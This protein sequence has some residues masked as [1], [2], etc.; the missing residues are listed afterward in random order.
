MPQH[1]QYTNSPVQNFNDLD[2]LLSDLQKFGLIHDELRQPIDIMM[3]NLNTD[4]TLK[5]LRYIN[6]LTIN[7]HN[8]DGE[9]NEEYDEEGFDDNFVPQASELFNY[10]EPNQ[11]EQFIQDF[12]NVIAFCIYENGYGLADDVETIDNLIKMRNLDEYR[13]QVKVTV[14]PDTQIKYQAIA[15]TVWF[16]RN[17]NPSRV[18]IYEVSSNDYT[19]PLFVGYAKW[20]GNGWCCYEPLLKLAIE[21]STHLHKREYTY[22]YCWRGFLEELVD[23]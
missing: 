17:Q 9:E 13:M 8:E 12:R 21:K 4:A 15:R 11:Q 1:P 22:S 2:K 19:N 7:I 10:L 23:Y 6:G 14:D 3:S 5:Y 16:P 18:G 20:N